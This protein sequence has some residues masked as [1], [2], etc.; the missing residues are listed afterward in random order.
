VGYI[1]HSTHANGIRI[2]RLSGEDWPR[3][4]C[5][6]NSA[7]HK[8]HVRHVIKLPIQL[9]SLNFVTTSP[10]YFSPGFALAADG[11]AAATR[12]YCDLCHIHA[13]VGCRFS[14]L[15]CDIHGEIT[16][17]AVRTQDV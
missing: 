15:H 14:V 9:P 2:G 5:N 6:V 16:A 10:F 13:Y 7:G 12:F 3:T 11:D 1:V 4:K 8:H 17:P